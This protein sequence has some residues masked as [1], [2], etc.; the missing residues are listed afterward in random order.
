[1]YM[2]AQDCPCKSNLHWVFADI[3]FECCPGY[4]WDYNSDVCKCKSELTQFIYCL[5]N[6][7]LFLYRLENKFGCIRT[8]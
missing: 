5:P 3:Y 2:Y 1:M 4:M 7:E 8:V 6:N